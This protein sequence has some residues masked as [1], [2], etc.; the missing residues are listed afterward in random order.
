MQLSKLLV[1]EF[2]RAEHWITFDS[3][4]W[5]VDGCRHYWGPGSHLRAKA[6]E[7]N[8]YLPQFLTDRS[9]S[10]FEFRGLNLEIVLDPR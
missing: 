2:K 3:E 8:V 9:R 5:S 4:S 1:R 6:Q 10:T 7:V